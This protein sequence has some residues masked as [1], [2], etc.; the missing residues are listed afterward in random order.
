[1]ERTPL[2][3]LSRDDLIGVVCACRSSWR[4][5]SSEILNSQ[6]GITNCRG[7]LRNSKRRIP[8]CGSMKHTPCVPKKSDRPKPPT[9]ANATS[10]SQR[11]EDASAPKKSW[12]KPLWK[13]TSGR[14]SS[15][16]Q[17]VSGDIRDRCGE[18]STVRP[19]WL[20]ITFMR[21]RMAPCLRFQACQ[22][23]AN[24]VRKSAS[25]WPTS[26]KQSLICFRT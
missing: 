22:S 14:S 20:R 11:D 16:S 18:L 10:R 26:I 19:C 21:G 15:S 17:N 12:P 2:H 24:S 6:N 4:I 7:G 1:M 13:K 8:R 25:R 5:L 9:T 23:V 3:D